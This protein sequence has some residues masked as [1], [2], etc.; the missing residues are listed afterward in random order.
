[1]SLS[2]E[3]LRDL[4]GYIVR[5]NEACEDGDLELAR[6]IARGLEETLTEANY[7]PPPRF[8]CEKCG[9]RFAWPGEL[10]DHLGFSHWKAAA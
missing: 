10:D 2:L 9:L 3:N 8:T 6:A 5:L 7:T 4:P 1:V